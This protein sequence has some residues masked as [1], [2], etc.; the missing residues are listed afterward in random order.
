MAT[1]ISLTGIK[2]TGTPHLGNLVG[3]IKPALALAET[4]SKA[5]YFIADY[6]ALTGVHDA[7]KMKGLVYEVAATW[8]AAGLDPS[9]VIFYRQ[10]DIPE[11]FELSWVL[12]CVTAKGLM[13][14][15]HAYKAA[16][17][18]NRKS[19]AAEED[20]DAGI[21]MGL[22]SYPVLMAADILLFRSTIVPV[23][24][25]QVQHVEYARDIAQRFNQTFGDV[26]VIPEARIDKDTSVVPGLDGRKMSKSYDNVIP[27]FV[28][29][30]KLKKLV[31]K[32]KTDSSAP[33]EP[34]DPDASYLF[35]LYREF[36]TPEETEALRKRYQTGIGWGEAKEAVYDVLNRALEEPRRRYTEYM[37]DPAKID[38]LL[39]EGG[40][41]ARE[42]ARSV[43][44]HVRRA[45]GVR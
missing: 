38:A 16:V 8:L 13:N 44:D 19:G 27:L 3:A 42:I 11:I 7:K 4:S 5:L 35:H 41:E 6:H 40:H 32:F 2:P 18:E 29:A 39:A 28:P 22:Y 24:K 26:F 37:A 36:A 10:S 9:K 31:F 14:R 17:E 1:T 30:E 43:M 12:S 33:S 23:G 34:K 25:D 20:L 21:N 45:V 15:A